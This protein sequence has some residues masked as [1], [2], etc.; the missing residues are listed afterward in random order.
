M[1]PDPPKK[2]RIL[3]VDDNRDLATSRPGC[4][5]C[6]GTKSEVVFDGRDV[7]EAE[8][9]RTYPP[10]SILLDIGLPGPGRLPGGSCPARGRAFDRMIIAAVSG[11]SLEE[12]RRRSLARPA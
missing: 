7:V 5:G 3:I 12:D 1:Q 8:L 11:Y 2:K 10:A 6:W 4:S 9:A